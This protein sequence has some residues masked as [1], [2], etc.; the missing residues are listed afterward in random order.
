MDIT[1]TQGESSFSKDTPRCRDCK[2]YWATKTV[3]SGIC[4]CEKC[5]GAKMVSISSVCSCNHFEICEG[6]K[7]VQPDNKLAGLFKLA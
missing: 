6:Q 7:P 3:P 5:E 2:N 1:T 4:L